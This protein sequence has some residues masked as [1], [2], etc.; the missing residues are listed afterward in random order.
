MNKIYLKNIF[1]YCIPLV[2]IESYF[3]RFL[4]IIVFLFFKIFVLSRYC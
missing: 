4:I 2:N 3:M 1:G